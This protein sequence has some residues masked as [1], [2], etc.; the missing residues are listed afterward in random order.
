MENV[1]VAN[2][3]MIPFGKYPDKSIKELTGMVLDNL[4][5]DSA[6]A[7]DHLEAAWFSNAGWGMQTG[8]ECIRGQVAL[9]PNG[10]GEIPVMNVENAAQEAHQRFTV[11]ISASLLALMMLLWPSVL[12]KHSPPPRAQMAR[13]KKKG[14]TPFWLEQMSKSPSP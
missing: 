5:K 3:G 11:L 8:Q 1:Y 14:S 2:V 7:K 10:I 13:P 9:M 12:R 4:L 6:I